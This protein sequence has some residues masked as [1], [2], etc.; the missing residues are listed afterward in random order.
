MDVNRSWVL[1]ALQL[2]AA[3]MWYAA[4][5]NSSPYHMSLN[6]YTAFMDDCQIPDNDS[7]YIKRSDCDTIFIVCNFVPDKK[8]PEAQVG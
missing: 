5:G 1:A 8:A 3:F 4:L 7:L 2:S 6:A